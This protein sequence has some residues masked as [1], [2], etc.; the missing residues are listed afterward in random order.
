MAAK[1]DGSQKDGSQNDVSQKPWQL[2]TGNPSP[3]QGWGPWAR[4]LAVA[5]FKP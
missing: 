3:D 5:A 4:G 1:N 2:K